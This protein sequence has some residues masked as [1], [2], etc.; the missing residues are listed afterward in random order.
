MNALPL[1]PS[2]GLFQ[3]KGGDMNIASLEKKVK[4]IVRKH[5]DAAGWPKYSETRLTRAGGRA[6]VTQW[7]VFTR[8]SRQAWASVVGNCPETEVRRFIVREN[9]YEE[10]GSEEKSHFLMLV[11]AGLAVGL[12]EQEIY[13]AKPVPATSAAMLVWESLTKNRHWMI[14]CAAKLCLELPSDP[15]CGNVAAREHA[16]WMSRLGLTEHQARF[17]ETHDELD[18][19]HGSGAF[20]LLAKYLVRQQVIT[21][22]DILQAVENSIYAFKLYMDGLAEAAMAADAAETGVG[23]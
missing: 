17:W 8:N 20:G 18:K 23:R 10:E 4:Q 3:A 21:E 1:S 22:E 11:D 15:E 5:M 13:N 9:L 6:Y 19:V 7:G 12:S 2:E 14:G 16:N